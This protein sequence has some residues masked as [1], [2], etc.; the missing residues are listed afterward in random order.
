M[1]SLENRLDAAIDNLLAGVPVT[2]LDPELAG[3]LAPASAVLS[4]AVPAPSRRLARGRMMASVREQQQRPGLFVWLGLGS[5][6]ASTRR[7]LRLAPMATVAVM[8]ILILL[9]GNA[10]PGQAHYPL[11]RGFE[12]LRLLGIQEPTARSAFYVEL[13]DHRLTELEKL[14]SQQSTISVAVIES[15]GQA[16]TL[17][18]RTPGADADRM[19]EVVMDHAR[20]LQALIPLL[21]PQLQPSAQDV[22][23]EITSLAGLADPSPTSTPVPSP[24]VLP[25]RTPS[26]QRQ[27]FADTPILVTATR[28]PLS[29]IT[30]PATPTPNTTPTPL[31]KSTSTV[32]PEPTSTATP[33]STATAV[34]DDQ[35]TRT[36]TSIP[37]PTNTP[38]PAP[39][40][41]PTQSIDPTQ[42]VEPT[43]T[44]ANTATP[45]VTETPE[46]EETETPEP[47]ETEEPEPEE[48]ETPEPEETEEPEPE[49]TEI[50]EA[51]NN[52]FHPPSLFA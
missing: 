6:Q 4:V 29:T 35:P 45:A 52:D 50:P 11:K 44:P 33:S 15:I 49:E 2:D 37:V 21:P 3:L 23:D 32:T 31:V 17:A 12:A 40:R 14:E 36:P 1:A 9:S 28:T 48:T 22:L 30:A 13:A 25:D 26:P 39:T 7:V 34:P 47:E 43:Q 46:P 5:W 8:I 18:Y 38:V 51:N 41:T 20:R 42:T 16:W 24:T 27:E 10:L 19:R